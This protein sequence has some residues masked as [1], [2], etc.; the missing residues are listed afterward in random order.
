MKSD[1]TAVVLDAFQHYAARGSFRS[2]TA[3]SAASKTEL[4]FIW[5]RDVAFRVVFDPARRTLTFVDMLPAIAPRSE[6]DRSLRAFVKLHASLA[7][8]EHRRV[9]PRR[10]AVKV[11]NRGGAASVT[12]SFKTRDVSYGVRKAVH[13]AHDI[14]QDFLNDGR[15]IHYCVEHFNVSPEMA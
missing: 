1:E 8:P 6:M 9:D 3:V 4:R 10:V 13:L 15:Y 11:I 5:L 2:L 12:C 7:V 14:L